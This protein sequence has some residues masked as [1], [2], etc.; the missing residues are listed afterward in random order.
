M[1]TEKEQRK[2]DEYVSLV[3]YCKQQ[4]ASYILD[5]KR[6]NISRD[7]IAKYTYLFCV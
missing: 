2:G 4:N 7:L 5:C 1:K 6:H 3:G